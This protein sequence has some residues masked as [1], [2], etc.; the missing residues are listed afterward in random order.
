[1]TDRHT[2]PTYIC[3]QLSHKNIAV[4]T[5]SY[6]LFVKKWERL[7]L[8]YDFEGPDPQIA[9]GKNMVVAVEEAGEGVPGLNQV[10]PGQSA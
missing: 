3:D 7:K 6:E 9:L 1:M 2:G 4:F 10:T 8:I 5:K